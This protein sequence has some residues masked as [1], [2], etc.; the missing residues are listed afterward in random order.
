M[1][2]NIYQFS[3]RNYRD[4]V[5]E[6]SQYKGNVVLIVNTASRCGFTPQY[7]ALENIYT[8]FKGKGFAILAFPCG[9][10]GQEKT[11]NTDIKA[12]C[13]LQ[14]SITFDLFSKVNVNGVN[15][16]PL[17]THLKK[18][19]PGILGTECIKWNFTKFL[20]NKQGNVVKR[21]APTTSPNALVK[22]ITNLL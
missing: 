12:F 21:F 10:F 22:H 5:I 14:F 6:L 19:A 13:D 17:F 2:A 1:S 20:V 4:E 16:H 3:A 8:Q 9:Q 18:H 7:K 15:T 11:N